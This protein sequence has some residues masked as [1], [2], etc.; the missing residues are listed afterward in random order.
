MVAGALPRIRALPPNQAHIFP[1]PA[2]APPA[3]PATPSR[4]IRRGWG[5]CGGVST[6]TSTSSPPDCLR[7]RRAIAAATHALLDTDLQHAEH[8]L[9]L[10]ADIAGVGQDYEHAAARLLALQA[11]VAGELR[12]VVTA[13]QIHGDLTRMGVLAEHI[14]EIARRRHPEPAVPDSVRP[15]LARM[16]S[17]AIAAATNAAAVLATRDPRRS[18]PP[19]RPGRHHERVAPH[20]AWPPSSKKLAAKPSPPPSISS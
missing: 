13:V 16:G 14:A 1:L 8:A 20:P 11:P 15:I 7:D 17:A 9:D 2:A 19:G 6:R 3:A 4:W 12:Q 18:R 10:C 5:G